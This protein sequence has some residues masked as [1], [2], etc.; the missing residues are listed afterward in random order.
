MGL[1]PVIGTWLLSRKKEN[2]M[3]I[4]AASQNLVVLSSELRV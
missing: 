1:D 2:E 4:A 3:A